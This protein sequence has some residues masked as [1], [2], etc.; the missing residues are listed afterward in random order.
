[1]GLLMLLFFLGI[2]GSF[3]SGLVGVGGAIVMYPL[4]LFIP[5]L[6]GFERFSSL[7]ISGLLAFQVFF[8]TLSGVIAHKKDGKLQL[9]L[10]WTIGIPALINGFLGGA[11]AKFVSDYFLNM[12]YG[13][14]AIVAIMMM[15]IP[16]KDYNHKEISKKVKISLSILI[17]SVVGFVSGMIG[18]GGAFL[19]VPLM[20]RIIKIST[21]AAMA[22]S[23][24]I[25][26]LS[27]IGTILG[28]ILTNS[29]DYH[30]A[31]WLAIAGLI[32]SPIGVRISSK[33][34]VKQLQWIFTLLLM[35]SVIKICWD[36][37][38]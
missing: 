25:T 16:Y 37:F 19:F 2:I 23:L 21:R 29:I 9:I 3:F 26:F 4:L 13:V 1:M 34:P 27:S 10:V 36:M 28:K 32:G 8:S 11:I 12:L 22:T 6:L 14:L 33:L 24:A 31:I 35:I 38:I 15:T 5:P 18:A 7:E 17:G 30:L 20:I